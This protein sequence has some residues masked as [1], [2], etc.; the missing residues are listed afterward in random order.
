MNLSKTFYESVTRNAKYGFFELDEKYRR[1]TSSFYKDEYYQDEH[2]LYQLEEYDEL[3]LVSKNNFYNQ[4]LYIVK[5]YIEGGHSLL[6]IGCGEGYAP[7]FF[8]DKGWTVKGIDFSS[9][10]IET[11]NPSKKD[12]LI[13]G[14]F[15]NVIN[16]LGK[17]NVTFDFINAD[18][19]LEHLPKPEEFFESLTKVSRNGTV[20]CVTVPNDFSRIQKL[21]FANDFIE[22]AFWVTKDTSEHFN[23][24]GVDSL[25]SLG[26][27]KGFEKIIAISDWPIDFFLLNNKTNYKK[28]TSLGHDCHVAC[29]LL[30]NAIYEDSM[31]KAIKFFSAL[32]DIGIG[33]EISVYFRRCV[34]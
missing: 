28:D 14:D 33:R 7:K 8:H 20:L 32:A 27:N 2:A 12:K 16:D 13:Q 34:E 4:K 29:S 26:N 11:H 19:V 10:G 17:D 22:D 18:N 1:I 25:S 5:K 24:F 23:Y 15:Y 31:D 9:Y 21:A 6:D 3:D 30:Q